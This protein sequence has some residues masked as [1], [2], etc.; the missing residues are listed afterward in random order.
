MSEIIIAI[1]ALIIAYILIIIWFMF[2]S[3]EQKYAVER[4]DLN[5]EEKI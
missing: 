5:R 3:E 4:Y 2:N 1:I